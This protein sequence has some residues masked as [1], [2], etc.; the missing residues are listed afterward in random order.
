[1]LYPSPIAYSSS[2]DSVMFQRRS[3]V[4]SCYLQNNMAMMSDETS[5]KK[6]LVHQWELYLPELILDMQILDEKDVVFILG[7]TS[8]FMASPSQG[9]MIRQINVEGVRIR[10]MHVFVNSSSIMQ[11]YATAEN[12]IIIY[13]GARRV[14]SSSANCD[15]IGLTQT[16]CEELRGCLCLLARNWT[17]NI[18]YLGTRPLK[19]VFQS[20]ET[21]LSLTQIETEIE[22]YSA[23][24][25][26]TPETNSQ[27]PNEQPILIKTDFSK[28]HIADQIE[29]KISVTVGVAEVSQVTRGRQS[30]PF[31]ADL[32]GKSLKILFV[33]S[34]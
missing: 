4:L 22:K 10:A 18:K 29:L 3:M 11:L 7:T 19:R 17:V 1:M 24:L 8:V 9:Q 33:G 13:S 21:R 12:Q 14:W 26:Q 5:T 16:T 32:C 6:S 23:I 31:S 28:T 30:F 34:A 15:I 25:C 27:M 2:N 20:T